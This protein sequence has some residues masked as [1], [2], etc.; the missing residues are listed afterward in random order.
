MI[1]LPQPN[2][3]IFEWVNLMKYFKVDIL[4]FQLLE[5]SHILVYIFLFYNMQIM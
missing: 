1:A 4:H 2:K 3:Y 5:M